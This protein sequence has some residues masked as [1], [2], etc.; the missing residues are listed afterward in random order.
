MDYWLNCRFVEKQKYL[1]SYSQFWFVVSF[2]NQ[3]LVFLVGSQPYT[4]FLY[5]KTNLAQRLAFAPML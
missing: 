5:F 4:W 3:Y 1:V 2:I